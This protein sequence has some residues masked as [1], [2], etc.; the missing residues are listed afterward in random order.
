MRSSPRT[1]PDHSMRGF[2]RWGALTRL[3]PA[4]PLILRLAVGS[5]MAA[6]GLAKLEVG[7]TEVWGGFFATLGLPAPIILAWTVTAIELVG[8]ICLILGL[9]AR[10]TALLFSGVMLGA[11]LLVSAELGVHSGP[12]GPGADLNL[13]LLAGAGAIVLI[14]PGRYALDA[15]LGLDGDALPRKNA[16]VEIRSYNLHPG[17]RPEFHRLVIEESV[18]LLERWDVDL[19]AFGP[20]P[21]DDRSYFL[22]RAFADL[23]DRQRSED[24][25]YGS[26][27][28]KDGPRDAILSLIESYTTIV[29]EVD[30]ATIDGLRTATVMAP[31]VAAEAP[32]SPHGRHPK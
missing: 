21:H 15:R 5:I 11:I 4:A 16:I 25:F 23:D 13:A 8:G 19:V 27:E 29:L 7:P 17:T 14:G 10:I 24:A 32:L 20:S 22:I 30:A 28:W 1:L 9:F 3:A 31:E 6:H 12:Q 18:P 2:P 26:D